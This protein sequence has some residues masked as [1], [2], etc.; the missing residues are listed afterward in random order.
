MKTFTQLVLN[1]HY[2][3]ILCCVAILL[4]SAQYLYSQKVGNILITNISSAVSDDSLLIR[5]SLTATDLKMNSRQSL[6]ICP[7]LTDGNVTTALPA[8]I[9]TGRLRQKYD[10]RKQLFSPELQLPVYRTFSVPAYVRI[11]T[12]EYESAIPYSPR[13]QMNELTVEYRY[14]DCCNI[15][16]FKKESYALGIVPPAEPQPQ[17][18]L[19]VAPEPEPA[20]HPFHDTIYIHQT[21]EILPPPAPKPRKETLYLEYPVNKYQIMED[22]GINR[23]ELY[24]LEKL[25]EG[26]RGRIGI[27]AYASPEGPYDKNKA[28]A[29]NRAKGFRDYL[30]EHYGYVNIVSVEHVAEDWDGLR[31][32]IEFSDF[33]EKTEALEIIDN[34]DIFSDREKKLMNLNKG[35]FWKKL[36]PLFRQLRRIEIEIIEN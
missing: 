26:Y 27:I 7:H 3:F 11:S 36:P 23:I 22:Y 20:P 12:L 5:F 35:A 2:N 6:T 8:I 9:F 31:E 28:L 33:A 24:K 4:I 16:P 18:V 14:D 32:L 34:V 25:L 19:P 10:E 17:P 21:V 29:A 1:K 30:Q 15:Y 13:Q